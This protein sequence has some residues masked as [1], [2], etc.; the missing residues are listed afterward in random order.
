MPHLQPI[1]KGASVRA[2]YDI[3]GAP[4]NF[5]TLAVSINSNRSV[6]LIHPLYYPI[7]L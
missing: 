6:A 5:R 3:F 4:L 2:H 1:I 7:F